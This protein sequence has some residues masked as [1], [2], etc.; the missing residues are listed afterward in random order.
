VHTCLYLAVL[1]KVM[2]FW[3]N[4]IVSIGEEDEQIRLDVD[5]IS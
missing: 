1:E 4:L 5:T 3:F 2:S